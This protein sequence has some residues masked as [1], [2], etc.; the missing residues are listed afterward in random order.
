MVDDYL[1]AAAE[2][3]AAAALVDSEGWDQ[4]TSADARAPD[5]RR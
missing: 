1:P 5:A 3:G 4:K 2:N